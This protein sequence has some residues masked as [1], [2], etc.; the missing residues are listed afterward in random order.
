TS[1]IV[2]LW[3]VIWKLLILKYIL[4]LLTHGLANFFPVKEAHHRLPQQFFTFIRMKRSIF[5]RLF[6]LIKTISV[7]IAYVFPPLKH[8]SIWN[9]HGFTKF[10]KWFIEDTD[11]I[12]KR[13]RHFLRATSS[14]NNR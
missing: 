14:S 13:L 11:C 6:N 3:H 9:R 8:Q 5:K 1:I 10:I 12:A 2:K 7:D 4:K